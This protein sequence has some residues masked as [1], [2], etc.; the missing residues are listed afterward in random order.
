MI[1]STS[2]VDSRWVETEVVDQGI[3]IPESRIDKLFE[4]F[5]RDPDVQ[6]SFKGTGLGLALVATVVKQHGGQVSASSVEGEGTT[7]TVRLPI[8]ELESA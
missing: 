6:K 3:G 4:R 7:I 8:H 1:I 2:I 5:H